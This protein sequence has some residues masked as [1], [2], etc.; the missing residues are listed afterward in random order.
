VF[1]ELPKVLEPSEPMAREP[2]DPELNDLN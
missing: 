1:A 2:D